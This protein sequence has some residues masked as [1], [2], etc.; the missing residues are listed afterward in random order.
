MK[1]ED[2]FVYFQFKGQVISMSD[3]NARTANKQDV[4][5]IQYIQFGHA[6]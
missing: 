1:L 4:H 5:V 2:D 6:I 3:F